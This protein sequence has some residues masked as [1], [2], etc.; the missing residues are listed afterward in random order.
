MTEAPQ[1]VTDLQT[2]SAWADDMRSRGQRIGFVPTMG[3]LHEGH[4]A[5]IDEARRHTDKVVVSIF[6]NPTQFGPNEDLA[7]YPRDLPGDLRNI[8]ARHADIAFVPDPADIYPKGYQTYVDVRGVSQGLCGDRRPGHFVGVATVVLK[9]FNIVRPHVAV[10]GEKDYQQLAVIRAM[11]AD[12]N[13]P[14]QILSLPTV[15]DTDGLALSSRNVYLQPDQRTRAVALSKSISDVLARVARGERRVEPLVAAAV[16]I[17][18]AS[19]DRIDYV[20]IRDATTLLPLVVLDRPAIL[21]VAA[22]LGTTRL[23]D[24]GRLDPG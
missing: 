5:L 13:V 9:L 15:R 6:V 22:F 20:E 23:I 19:V 10:F 12:L 16:Q 3:H 18:T 21:V 8:G 1:V 17:L 7:R 2:M 24:N 14:V 4:L 11:V